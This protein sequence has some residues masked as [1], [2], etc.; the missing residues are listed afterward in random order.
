VGGMAWLTLCPGKH[1]PRAAT[2]TGRGHASRACV[3]RAAPLTTA[4]HRTTETHCPDAGWRGATRSQ[5]RSKRANE[6]CLSASHKAL[7]GAKR[8][9]EQHTKSSRDAGICRNKRHRRRRQ[10]RTVVLHAC[11]GVGMTNIRVLA[12]CA[13]L[14]HP[15]LQ[16][17]TKWSIIERSCVW[18][19]ILTRHS[20]GGV[21]GVASLPTP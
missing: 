2:I 10:P 3:N 17:P 8:H 16:V 12:G 20:G 9:A 14:Q 7:I 13:P 21:A 19:L 6:L 5:A 4:A 18:R 15:C 1:I 11:P